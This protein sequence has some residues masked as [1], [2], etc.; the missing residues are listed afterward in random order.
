MNDFHRTSSEASQKEIEQMKKNPMVMSEYLTPKIALLSAL[1]LIVALVL[2]FLV[3]VGLYYLLNNVIFKLFNWFNT[4][5]VFWKILLLFF[6]GY[7]IFILLMNL[8][9]RL[10]TLLGGLLFNKLPQNYFTLIVP[11]VLAFAN[12]VVCIIYLWKTPNRYTFWV[13][14]EL[15][16]LSVFIWSL[17]AIVIPAKEQIKH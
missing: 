11:I 1:Y 15:L 3:D 12:A 16:I 7:S 13:I 2:L 6:G 17:S 14:C 4:L 8:T 10:A 9:G 5:N